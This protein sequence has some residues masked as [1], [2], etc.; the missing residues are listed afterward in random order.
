MAI[1]VL[2]AVG[3]GLLF[4]Q[5]RV[6]DRTTTC[7]SDF[8]NLY[9]GGK[10]AFSGHIYSGSAEARVQNEALGCQG[11]SQFLRLPY[12]AGLLWP[13][14][15]LPFREAL[16]VWRCLCVAAILSLAWLWPGPRWHALA[17]CV[18]SFPLMVA[19]AYGQDV[20]I[21][22]L[23]AGSGIVLLG[24]KCDFRAGL[25]LSLGAAKPHLFVVLV[26]LIL[27]QRRWRAVLGLAAGGVA[28]IGANFL[29]GGLRWP[30][31]FWNTVTGPW[32]NPHASNM[33][34][35]H[36]MISAFNAPWWLEP[37][38]AVAFLVPIAWACLQA[39]PPMSFALALAGGVL[40]GFHSYL[41]DLV[42][43]IP[44]L[45]TV[46]A[47]PSL[48]KWLK[49]A[50]GIFAS[51]VLYLI[52]IPTAFPGPVHFLLPGFLVLTSVAILLKRRQ[53]GLDWPMLPAEG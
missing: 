20:P 44:L 33:I 13:L 50:A 16:V 41:Y 7:S 12:L 29:A 6:G 39:P 22:L 3:I 21:V 14:A 4:A 5:W 27:V 18:W 30:V 11:Y 2:A 24:R 28:I 10:L 17:V 26:L 42:F 40:V 53:V 25:C 1:A 37:V 35:L 46:L 49:W 34:N 23:A 19:L 8:L 31:D 15:Q 9:T 32:A 43:S 38:L 52:P 51:P 36:G 48:P 47:S 45:L